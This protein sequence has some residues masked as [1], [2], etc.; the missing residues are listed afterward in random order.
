[1]ILREMRSIDVPLCVEIVRLNWSHEA[2]ARARVEL[3]ASLDCLELDHHHWVTYHNGHLT[4]FAGMMRSRK[5]PGAW[6]FT[7][8]AA[9][10]DYQGRGFGVA[11]TNR[12]IAEVER[13]DGSAIEVTTRIPNWFKKFGF[14]K[15]F[16]YEGGLTLMVK[17]LRK[18]EM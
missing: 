15:A 10:P 2:A 4:A 11:L 17:Q 12:R 9:R 6:S 13:R 14:K 5:T 16:A 18:V 8:L 7:Y 3:C 1:M